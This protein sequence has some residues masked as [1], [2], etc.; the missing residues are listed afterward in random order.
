MK[1]IEELT[2]V[3]F[4]NIISGIGKKLNWELK[5]AM[6]PV[7]SD[8]SKVID[9]KDFPLSSE[10]KETDR[11]FRMSDALELQRMANN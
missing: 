11:V 2:Y 9:D 10:V 7:S 4:N 3:Q 8:P 6:L 1:D 5:L